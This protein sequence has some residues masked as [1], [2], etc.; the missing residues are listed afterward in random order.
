MVVLA[1]SF[2]FTLFGSTLLGALVQP[3][4]SSDT[5]NPIV[6]DRIRREWTE[7][8]KRHTTW[9]EM[10]ETQRVRWI[11]ESNEHEI[12][13]QKMD[14]EFENWAR[15][16]EDWALEKAGW[17]KESE[18]EREKR[19]K[20]R[21]MEEKEEKEYRERAGILWSNLQQDP[22]CLRYGARK[23]SAKLE[24]VP[25]SYNPIKACRQTPIAIHGREILPTHCE[26]QADGTWGIWHV[27]F[28]EPWC[29]TW[30]SHFN[31]TGCTTE[32]SGLRRIEA[33]LENLHAGDDEKEMCG[34]TPARFY[35]LKFDGAM[36]CSDWDKPQPVGFWDIEDKE[37]LNH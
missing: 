34:T 13:R 22:H 33:Q 31:D 9:L 15:A 7:E 5:S 10:I 29:R 23:Y 18:S 36:G 30:W 20:E 8:L 3:Y 26:H 2:V 24:H 35:G 37:C 1:V 6:R 11:Q 12:L 19:R 16:R 25:E 14:R 32:G 4:L 17:E 28:N 21:E 27:D